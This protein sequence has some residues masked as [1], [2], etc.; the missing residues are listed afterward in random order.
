MEFLA[1][2][3]TAV[4]QRPAWNV[5]TE[6][7]PPETMNMSVAQEIF[8]AAQDGRLSTISP[9]SIVRWI[10][11]AL[12]SEDLAAKVKFTKQRVME[13]APKIQSDKRSFSPA[14]IT[15]YFDFFSNGS[16]VGILTAALLELKEEGRVAAL[17]LGRAPIFSFV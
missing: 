2:D 10:R 12:D 13:A 15:G 5:K 3:P 16:G 14:E 4:G 6:A 7:E 17:D 11:A 9:E 8:E 1:R